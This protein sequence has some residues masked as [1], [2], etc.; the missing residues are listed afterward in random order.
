MAA[1]AAH[2]QTSEMY[3]MAGDQS[4]FH[5]IR[6]GALIRSW[7]LADGTARYQYPIAVID[8][9]RT[10][11]ANEGDLGAEYDL[12]GVDLGPRYI[13]E[14]GPI[15]CWD[16]TTDATFNYSIDTAGGVYRFNRDWSDPVL[17]FD[18][19]S[20]GALT[21]DPS[22]DSLW[23]SQ[24]GT[25]T[26]INYT[27]DGAVISSFSTG[28]TQN[29]ALALDHADGT[30]WL[31]DR[32]AQGTYEQWTRDGERLT[33]FGIRGMEGENALGGEF[34]FTACDPC[35]MNCDG[36]IDT[37]DIEPFLD[38]LFGG[39]DPCDECTGDVNGDGDINAFDIEPFLACLFP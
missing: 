39:G 35:D 10:M 24:F 25:E 22:N 17:L 33:R 5:V 29:M 20:I 1:A 16:G 36:Q 37:F 21:Y 2:A 12:S 31:H 32:N 13:H 23:V 28:H 14:P 15:R 19:G 4:T 18:A 38:L 6:N 11:G 27:M 34:A 3:L 7:A 8:S 26:I 30:L 9:V